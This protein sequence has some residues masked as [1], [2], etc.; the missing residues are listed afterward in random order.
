[1]VVVA[2]AKTQVLTRQQPISDIL[3]PGFA[4]EYT[5]YATQ[6]EELAVGIQFFSPTAQ[7]VSRNI[8]ILDPAGRNAEGQCVRDSLLQGDNGV[9]FSCQIYASGDWQIRLF[10]REGESSGVYVV[11]V[12]TFT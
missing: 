11:A 1:V 12:E 5:F 9:I 2:P 4:H 6:G 3:E 10:G 7:R 8:A